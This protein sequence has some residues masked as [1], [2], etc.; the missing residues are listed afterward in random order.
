M[1]NRLVA[2]CPTVPDSIYTSSSGEL[3]RSI[4]LL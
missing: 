1:N 2:Q 3:L 4:D